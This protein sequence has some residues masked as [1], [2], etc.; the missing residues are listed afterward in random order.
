MKE[1]DLKVLNEKLNT[2]D[3]NTNE[4]TTFIKERFLDLFEGNAFTIEKAKTFI[5]SQEK[6]LLEENL[7]L[8]RNLQTTSEQINK[9][10][11][12]SFKKNNEQVLKYHKTAELNISLKQND[13]RE[14]KSE[15]NKQ[16]KDEE[17]DFNDK[18]INVQKVYEDELAEIN[19]EIQERVQY[20]KNIKV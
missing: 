17:K 19:K 20:K 16:I 11:E 4:T 5:K 8:H 12:L 14:L 15:I 1:F 10:F 3:F 18:I 13:L 2:L 9:A 7:K 6:N